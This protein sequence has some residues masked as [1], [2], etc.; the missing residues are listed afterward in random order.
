MT[1]NQW[2]KAFATS[3]AEVPGHI[4]PA[5]D[6]AVR[7]EVRPA[8]AAGPEELLASLLASGSRTAGPGDT[9]RA[10][11]RYWTWLRHADAAR[12]T[13]FCVA[14]GHAL[15]QGGSTPRAWVPVILGDHDFRIVHAATLAYLRAR[16]ASVDRLQRRVTD[17]LDWIRRGLA[18]ERAAVFA[19]LLE[20][21]DDDVLARLRALRGALR[22]DETARVWQYAVL[23]DDATRAFLDEWR[24]TFA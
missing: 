20:L 17:A 18:L 7:D 5:V 23:P 19:A 12:R 24:A 11:T 9:G 22:P 8:T 4:P 6:G 14:L 13:T 15:E 3:W 1:T 21:A 16:P 2:P 10:L